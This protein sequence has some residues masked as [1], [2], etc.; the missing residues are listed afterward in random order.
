MI[1]LGLA[2]T[3]GF[4]QQSSFS[5]KNAPNCTIQSYILLVPHTRTCLHLS[6]VVVPAH[7]AGPALPVPV[8]VALASH[9]GG[10][11]RAAPA[12]ANIPAGTPECWGNGYT[13]RSVSS[14]PKGLKNVGRLGLNCGFL[15]VVITVFVAFS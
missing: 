1:L 12:L 3:I 14:I 5:W 15:G 13:C 7:E 4:T 10:G 11:R 2:S 9:A 6:A 8:T